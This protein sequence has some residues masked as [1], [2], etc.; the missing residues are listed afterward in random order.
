V[1]TFAEVFH[2]TPHALSVKYPHYLPIYETH[3]APF[4]GQSVQVLEI[5]VGCGGF[6]QVLQTYLGPQAIVRGLDANVGNLIPEM[7]PS[8]LTGFQEDTEAHRRVF[9]ALPSPSIIIDDGGHQ[10]YEQLASFRGLFPRLATPGVYIVEDTQ[11][12]YAPKYG[13]YK[14]PGTFIEFVKDRV[15]DLNAWWAEPGDPQAT[16]FTKMTFGIHIYPNCVVFEKT[17][18]LLSSAIRVEVPHA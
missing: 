10:P 5:G 17:P 8:V 11:F 13:G 9:E 7:I 14:H 16:D 6:L 3:L 4:R 1:L 18:V 15:D 12:S 2:T